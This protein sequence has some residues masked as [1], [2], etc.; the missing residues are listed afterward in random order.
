MI[1]PHCHITGSIQDKYVPEI[2]T[3]YMFGYYIPLQGLQIQICIPAGTI[4]ASAC[5]AQTHSLPTNAEH[6]D[7]SE[8]TAVPDLHNQPAKPTQPS[9]NHKHHQVLILCF[10]KHLEEKDNHCWNDRD[11][12]NKPHLHRQTS[13]KQ[14]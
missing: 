1:K 14:D 6:A 12:L 11:I 7:P 10:T 8:G 4:P 5:W 3:H 9:A 13:Q 2:F